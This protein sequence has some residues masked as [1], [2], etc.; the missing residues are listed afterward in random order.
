VAFAYNAV[1]ARGHPITNVIEASTH[2][3]AVEQL[4]ARGLF[5]TDVREAQEEESASRLRKTTAMIVGKPGNTRDLMMFT[6]QMSMMLRAGSQV[7][8]AM[9]AIETLIDKPGWRKIVAAVR[10]EVETGASLSRALSAY[11]HIFDAAFRAIVTAGEST[12]QA[13]AAFD[14][15]AMMMK[16]QQQTK[17][18]VIGTLVYPALLFV[19]SLG[20]VCVLL[21]FVLPR[22]DDVYTM[23]R[24]DLPL[25]TQIMLAI[26]RWAK[27]HVPF[28]VAGAIL[29]TAAPFIAARFSRTRLWLDGALV[30]LPVVGSLAGRLILARVLRVWGESVRAS[31][32]LLESLDLARE[33]TRNSVYQRMVE[34]IR[35][36]V[37]RGATVAHAAERQP[38]IPRTM[39]STMATGEQSGQLGEA[40]VFLADYLDDENRQK[41][42]ALTRLVEPIILIFMGVVVGGVAISLFLPLF[43]LTEAAHG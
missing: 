10:H 22:F 30:R 6:R 29:L 43:N 13:G 11:P 8:P 20:V 41:L 35:D 7:V 39:S 3:E 34:E 9:E 16:E 19:M 17:M 33:V 18:R 32:P 25:I 24:T 21:F 23:L 42:A 12:G 5:V 27:H 40:I 1:D 36:A 2:D 31:V 15:L 4:H 26:S 28:L 14:R 38:R 37:S